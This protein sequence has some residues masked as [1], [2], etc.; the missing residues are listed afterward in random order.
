MKR[1]SSNP[2]R[3]TFTDGT[4]MDFPSLEAVE[5]HDHPERAEC[6]TMKRSLSAMLASVRKRANGATAASRAKG[7]LEYIVYKNQHPDRF[8]GGEERALDSCF[9]MGDGDDVVRQLR[10]MAARTPA[11]KTA[12]ERHDAKWAEYL[13]TTATLAAA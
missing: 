3:V 6:G 2:V 10:L 4:V 11:V 8:E 7:A 5:F 12:F 13:F 1:H 9:E